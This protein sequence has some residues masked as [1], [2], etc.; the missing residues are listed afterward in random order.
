M[1]HHQPKFGLIERP[2]SVLGGTHTLPNLNEFSENFRSK[3]L[4]QI[5]AIINGNLV[6]NVP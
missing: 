1:H 4:L 3:N 2:Y 6:M 5:F